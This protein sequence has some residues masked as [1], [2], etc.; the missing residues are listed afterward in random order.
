MNESFS[1]LFFHTV[2]FLFTA[3]LALFAEKGLFRNAFEWWCETI[4]MEALVALIADDQLD[5]VIIKVFLADL[6]CHILKAFVPFLSSD[7]S[8]SQTQIPFASL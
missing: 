8:G 6:A 7:V 1:S 2:L 5:I 3:H 4:D